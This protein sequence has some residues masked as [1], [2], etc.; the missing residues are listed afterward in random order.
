M[1]IAVDLVG[2]VKRKISGGRRVSDNS[3]SMKSLDFFYRTLGS[4]L[5]PLVET[6]YRC[7]ARGK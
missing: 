6:D 5:P 7:V 2:I 4:A 3:D 1:T